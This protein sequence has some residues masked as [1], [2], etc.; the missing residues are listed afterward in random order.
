MLHAMICLLGLALVP[1]GAA[2][3]AAVSP[4]ASVAVSPSAAPVTAASLSG[5][6][7]GLS[8]AAGVG[9][10]VTATA[11]A[12]LDPVPPE[13][14]ADP[15]S[16]TAQTPD[17]DL[18]TL[19][20]LTLSRLSRALA[21]DAPALWY[22]PDQDQPLADEAAGALRVDA[23]A[24]YTELARRSD[25]GD[26]DARQALGLARLRGDGRAETA[27]NIKNGDAGALSPAA[28]AAAPGAAAGALSASAR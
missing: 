2:R 18:A 5:S 17:A 13:E 25:G 7:A 19:P 15:L 3:A 8:P 12:S 22:D 26:K 21:N 23:D 11:T 24:L 9:P 14:I 27:K 20:T 6:A 16:I 28:Q 4:V 1:A 10:A